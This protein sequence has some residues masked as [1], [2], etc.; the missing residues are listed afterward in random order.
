MNL[1]LFQE[2]ELTGK[3]SIFDKRAKHILSILK[4]KKN[5][6]FDI[7]KINGPRGKGKI[8]AITNESIEL[9][10]YWEHAIPPLFPISLIIGHPRPQSVRRILKD[11]TSLGVKALYFIGTE[12]GEA[13]YL[14][15]K[16]WKQNQYTQ[17]LIEGAEQAFTTRIP[18]VEI[19]ASL[20]K[21][22]NSK[23]IIGNC[24]A[25][26]NYE[27]SIF[28]SKYS[29][30][31]GEYFLAVGPERGWS[32]KER[33]ILRNSDFLLAGLGERVLKTDTA[34]IVGTTILLSKLNLL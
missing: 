31:M 3:I 19:F 8:K 9:S 14:N 30:V 2:K 24:I 25:L 12:K 26:D 17:Y 20:A 5:D 1:I 21:F 13:S 7:G 16:L 4:C 29:P 33:N 10:Y 6:E 28:L 27:N 11:A 32:D 18:K 22:I 34:S 23:E 15:S